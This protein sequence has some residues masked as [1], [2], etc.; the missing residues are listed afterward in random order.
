MDPEKMEFRTLTPQEEAGRRRRN[1]V[2]A[3]SLFVISFLFLVT[4][5]IRIGANLGVSAS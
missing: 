1:I 2:I 4:T 5:M 3:V